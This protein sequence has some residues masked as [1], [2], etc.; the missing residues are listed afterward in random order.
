MCVRVVSVSKGLYLQLHCARI[1]C[2]FSIHALHVLVR[3]V[4][5][6][7]RVTNV[8]KYAREKAMKRKA[9]QQDAV[10]LLLVAVFIKKEITKRRDGVRRGYDETLGNTIETHTVVTVTWNKGSH[11]G[12]FIFIL[13]HFIPCFAV[14]VSKQQH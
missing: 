6:A 9:H 12:G 10:C 4:E 5:S 13:C 1:Q 14:F 3:V 11:K 8:N 7:V 2:E